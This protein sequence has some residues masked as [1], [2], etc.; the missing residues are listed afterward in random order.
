MGRIQENILYLGCNIAFDP[1][2]LFGAMPTIF[3]AYL[4]VQ[5]GRILGLELLF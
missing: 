1:E 4:G 5:A 3:L 2:N